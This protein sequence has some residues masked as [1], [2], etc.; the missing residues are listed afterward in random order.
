M[1][2]KGCFTVDTSRPDGR[3]AFGGSSQVRIH[4]CG[5]RM[6]SLLEYLYTVLAKKS[7]RKAISKRSHVPAGGGERL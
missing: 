3:D 6:I 5:L 1:S 7:A 2:P 4:Y